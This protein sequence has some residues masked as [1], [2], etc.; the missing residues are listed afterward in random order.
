MTTCNGIADADGQDNV[1]LFGIDMRTVTL[2]LMGGLF[3]LT[4]FFA[5]L[6]A[7]LYTILCFLPIV[8]LIVAAFGL[9]SR[10]LPA[11]HRGFFA[12]PA[13]SRRA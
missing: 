7:D 10:V 2:P 8:A 1:N 5:A 9:R 6:T 13:R 11:L 3:L 12:H 4:A